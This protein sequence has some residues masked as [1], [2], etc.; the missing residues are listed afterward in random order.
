[1]KQFIPT[2]YNDPH[3]AQVVDLE[4]ERKIEKEVQ[5]LVELHDFI[6]SH[7]DAPVKDIARFMPPV[8]SRVVNK[9]IQL[10]ALRDQTKNT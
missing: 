9:A 5:A 4:E 6:K 3:A 1:M 8:D 7:P 10:L 2:G